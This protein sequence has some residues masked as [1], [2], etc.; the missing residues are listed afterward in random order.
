MTKDKVI[1]LME[2]HGLYDQVE[3]SV[4]HGEVMFQVC[5]VSKSTGKKSRTFVSSN[6]IDAYMESAFLA[7]E[8]LQSG[9][10]SVA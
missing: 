2:S 5:W 3:E 1:A 6:S 9:K 4:E 7:L 10:L 8:D